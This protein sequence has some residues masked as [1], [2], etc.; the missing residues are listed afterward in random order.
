M[1]LTAGS[2]SPCARSSAKRAGMSLRIS[3]ILLFLAAGARAQSVWT[4]SNAADRLAAAAGGG[5]LAYFDPATT[6]WGAQTVFGKTGALGLP[7]LPG[8]DADVMCFP[9]CT[10]GQGFALTHGAAANGPFGETDGLVSNYTIIM[11]VL[12]PAASDGRWRA[13]WQAGAANADDAE[14]FVQSVPGGGIGT[15]G[16]YRGQLLPREWHRVAI[17]VRAAPAEG[18]AQRYIDGQYAGGVGTSGSG[19]G[20]R[21][22]LGPQALL[23]TDENGETAPGYCASVAFVPWAMLPAEVAALGGPH[24]GGA[25]T[26]GA[27]PAPLPPMARR[28]GVI[29][30][31]G[32]SF[33]RAPDNTLA[34]IRA[35]I[36]DGV[37]AIEVDTRVSSDGVVM[38]FHDSTVDRTTNGTGTTA[39]FTAAQLQALDAGSSYHPSFAGEK[40][41]TLAEVFTEAKG[42]CIIFLD[43][44]TDGQAAAVK[45]AM[46]AAAFPLSDL[47][48]WATSSARATDFRTVLPG[49][50]LFTGA[51]AATWQTDANYFNLIRTQGYIGFSFSA[52]S[53]QVDP[54][55]CARAKDEGMLVEIFT[56]LDPDSLR[57]AAESGVDFVEND[58]P[59]EMTALQ[60]VQ[61]LAA[62]QPWPANGATG[63]PVDVVLRWVTAQGA[64]RRRVFFGTTTP[65]TDLGIRRSD[66][67][68]RQGLAYNTTYHW[69]VDEM[70]E[71]AALQPGPVW[72]FTTAAAPP[73]PQLA[74]LWLFDRANDPGHATIGSDLVIEGAPPQWL[75]SQADD[76]GKSAGGV[77]LTRSGTA[78]RLRASHTIGASNGGVFTNRYSIVMDVLSPPGSRSAWRSLLQTNP[79]NNGDGDLFLR[80]TDDALGVAAL[81]YGPVVNDTQWTRL[82]F[83]ADLQSTAAASRVQSFLDGGAPFTHTAQTRDGRY[84]LAQSLLFFADENDENA[85]VYVGMIA[86]YD[87]PLTAPMVAALGATRG[88]GL[89]ARPAPPLLM[90]NDAELS[91]TWPPVP[92]FLLQRSS[93]LTNWQ[94]L[95]PTLGVGAW[96]E[97]F[98][99]GKAFFRLAPR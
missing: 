93:D 20:L 25:L 64:T 76:A 61:S 92:G 14:F 9:A 83:T 37:A 1:R 53:G 28:T 6:G 79:N 4:F 82:V 71:S 99:P 91:L 81:A 31:R 30:H 98:A 33:N 12:W 18:H 38:A 15:A 7:A 89:F 55:F 13:L 48:V 96:A 42:K 65:G 59:A 51:P 2:C 95:E 85:P 5:T 8:G 39:S 22:A 40:V 87:G 73:V 35:G 88:E 56:L 54:F 21:Y 68:A 49:V 50:K 19:L 60:P 16:N 32:G 3:M 84:S 52:G 63:V 58:C 17:A 44:K 78:N 36:A 26:P 62:S 75:A 67:L 90:V 86:L 11:D 47:W 66:L 46:E 27:P 24:A 45:T 72:S 34:A 70:T 69:R 94:S 29:G 80:D 43:L 57:R 41:P 10:A 74:G 97:P 23:F 77:I